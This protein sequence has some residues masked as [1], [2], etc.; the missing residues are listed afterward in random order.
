MKTDTGTSNWMPSVAQIKPEPAVAAAVAVSATFTAEPIQETLTFWFDELGLPYRVE[1]APYNQVFQQL[2]DPSSLLATN[3][4]AANVILLRFEDWTNGGGIEHL[5]QTV[6][7]F[8]SG[9]T[10]AV[11]SWRTPVIVAQCPCSP[12]FLADPERLEAA[13]KMSQ[14]L[15]AA[16]EPLSAVHLI[17]P[18]DLDLYYPVTDYHDP[19]ADELGHV[20]YTPEYFAALGTMVARKLDAMRRPAY[21]VIALDAD[22]TLW[23]GVCAEDGPSGICL[24]PDRR[25]LQEFMRAQKEAGVLLSMV[26]KNEDDD[27]ADAF[28]ANPEMPLQLEDFTA[29]RVNWQPKSANL[30]SLAEEL[31]LGL[32]SFIFVDDN[33]TEIAEVQAHCPEVLALALPK[34]DIARFLRHVWAF[35]RLKATREDRERSAMYAQNLERTRLEKKALSLQD[36]L[37]A[38][39]LDIRIQPVQA[40]ELAR[41]AQLTQRTNQMN[42]TTVRRTEMDL[43]D[44]LR[45]G[46]A[47]CLVV[48]LSDRF[49]SYGLVGVMLFGTRADTLSLDTFLLSCRALGKGVEHRMM[50]RL[51]EIARERGLAYV[52]APFAQSARNRPALDLLRTI[53]AAYQT[54]REGGLLFRF[55]AAALAAVAYKPNGAVRPS[56]AADEKKPAAMPE[57]RRGTDYTA[58]A[59]AL[60]DPAAIVERVRERREAAAPKRKANGAPRTD[61]ERALVALWME[62]L[63]VT[64]VGVH[65]NF[66]DLGGHSLLAVQLISRVRQAH[67]VDLSL[68]LVYSGAFTIEALAQAIEVAQIEQAGADQYASLLAELETLSDDEVR[69]LLAQEQDHAAGN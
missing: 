15:R 34:E 44:L 9:L 20:P 30:I 47:E 68:E 55:P 18:A 37:G 63:G 46:K 54:P 2:L 42:F 38:L 27:V 26:S 43:R 45:S 53:G 6:E 29:R 33:P 28:R 35:D 58:I 66:F 3:N 67:E 24:D 62:L 14:V 5:Y 41:V 23:H 19:H 49:G 48:H 22:Y 17:T 59:L 50:A 64:S 8:A 69:A 21:K 31:S 25:A 7:Q 56:V 57:E 10:A 60:W 39:E 65:D 51:G 12:G 32:D 36:F 13:Q 52:D 11:A 4:G 16:I 40:E 61:L 1:F